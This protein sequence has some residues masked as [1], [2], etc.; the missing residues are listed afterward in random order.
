LVRN[1]PKLTIHSS[2]ELTFQNALTFFTDSFYLLYVGYLLLYGLGAKKSV[3]ES[4]TW[5]EDAADEGDGDAAYELGHYL[6]CQQELE[7][8]AGSRYRQG[9]LA[10]HAGCMRELALLLL[11]E[12]TDKSVLDE[13]YDGGTEIRDLLVSASELGDKEAMYRL[14]QA[15][16]KGLGDIIPQRDITKALEYYT[17]AANE[18]HEWAMIRVSEILGNYMNKH[19]E[20]IEWLQKAS[21]LFASTKARVMLISY[22]FNRPHGS[23]DSRDAH[24]FTLLQSLI[25]QEIEMIKSTSIDDN[26]ETTQR[27]RE[28]RLFMKKS[29]LGLALYTLGQCYELGRGTTLQLSS[30]KDLYQRSVLIS[31]NTE[32]MW[33]LGFIYHTVE[34]NAIC[35]LEWFRK[36]AET[37]HHCDSHYQLG[38]FH[39]YGLAGLETNV[40]ASKKHLSKAVDG[41]HPMATYELAR[42][43]WYHSNDY[44]YGYE[45]YKVAGLQFH[46]AAALRE[47][48][49]LSHIGFTSHGIT[50]VD[51]DYKKAFALYCEAAQRG[52][53]TAALMVGNYFEEG[54]LL[55]ELGQDYERALQWYES[56]YRLNCGGL[57][58]LAIAKLKHILADTIIDEEEAEDIREEAIEWFESV[59]NNSAIQYARPARIMMALYCI[60]GWGRKVQDQEI[61]FEMLLK[62]AESGGFEALVPIAE[63]YEQG[64][65]TKKD[66][67]KA[68]KYWEMSAE[69]TGDKN[70]LLRLAEIYELGLTGKLDKDLADHYYH[71][72]AS[73]NLTKLVYSNKACSSR[74]SSKY[75]IG[76]S[77]L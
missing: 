36:A 64:I 58:E 74:N 51:R 69:H 46:V 32:A 44:F 34:N 71:R 59:A 37:G 11:A 50:I 39:L 53:P 66:M 73:C 54:Y 16:E 9:V 40:I 67:E 76:S 10:G 24:N 5:L 29:G 22:E 17:M 61:G 43:V 19:E 18:R 68:V 13:D 56:A 1:S 7:K 31:Q 42:L 62:I 45:L 14:G 35:A 6:H 26:N 38:L 57:A 21:T 41:G 48:G 23:K 27:E 33:R 72:A 4:I 28:E 25:D 65:G 3:Q 77:S 49:H 47:L 20:A 70:A 8:E 75:C 63:C 2:H 60:N 12:E 52:D 30:A 15:Y 55:K